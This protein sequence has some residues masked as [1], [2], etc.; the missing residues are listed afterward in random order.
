[1]YYKLSSWER[2]YLEKSFHS[3]IL[4]P[5]R[6]DISKVSSDC[7][8]AYFDTAGNFVVSPHSVHS[9][10]VLEKNILQAGGDCDAISRMVPP[11]SELEP[12]V[13]GIVTSTQGPLVTELEQGVD[14]TT[15]L[16]SPNQ[17]G[18]VSPVPLPTF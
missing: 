7:V 4:E 16:L 12:H 1:M 9:F 8:E 18:L 5:V 10:T 15:Q 2:D 3:T 17:S 6:D 13:D 14:P 11:T